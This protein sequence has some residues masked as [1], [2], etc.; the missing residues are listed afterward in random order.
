MEIRHWNR[1]EVVHEHQPTPRL[2]LE[3]KHQAVIG[4]A[5]IDRDRCIPWADQQNCLVCQEMCPL[6]E[7]AIELKEATVT[8]SEGYETTVFLPEVITERCTGC[9]I[10]EHQCPLRGEAAI[11]VYPV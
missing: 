11:R 5:E 9:G 3:E 10:C 8:N 7:K 2:S 4:K 1:L 6:P